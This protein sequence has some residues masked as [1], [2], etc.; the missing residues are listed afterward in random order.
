MGKLYLITT[1]SGSIYKVLDNDKEKWL[2]RVPS[3]EA[4]VLRK[5]EERIRIYEILQLTLGKPAIFALEPL[6]L[7]NLTLRETT[8]VIDIQTINN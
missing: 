1:F 7:G 5:D 2:E 4:T 8:I 6:G 3:Q